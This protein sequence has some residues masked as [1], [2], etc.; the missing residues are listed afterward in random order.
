MVFWE[1]LGF[2]YLPHLTFLQWAEA[3]CIQIFL[4][5]SWI[6]KNPL[7]KAEVYLYSYKGQEFTILNHWMKYCTAKLN[8]HFVVGLLIFFYYSNFTCL[9]KDNFLKAQMHFTIEVRLWG[10]IKGGRNF[11]FTISLRGCKQN[12]VQIIFFL[13]RDKF[14]KLAHVKLLGVSTFPTKLLSGHK[15]P[16]GKEKNYNR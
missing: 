2:S 5:I 8:S 3:L 16:C 10:H 1:N 4:C 7:T 6:K 11:F 12:V 13:A 14:V 9:L 15:F